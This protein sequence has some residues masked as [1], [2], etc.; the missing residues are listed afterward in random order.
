MYARIIVGS[1][2]AQAVDAHQAIIVDLFYRRTRP[3]VTEEHSPCDVLLFLS[4]NRD[5]KVNTNLLIQAKTAA[6]AAIVVDGPFSPLE[7]YMT[8]PVSEYSLLDSSIIRRISETTFRFQV[9]QDYTGCRL[10]SR[11]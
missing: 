6:S 10:I 8:L 3:T 7:A 9:I 1:F 4:R 2:P 11:R 5:R